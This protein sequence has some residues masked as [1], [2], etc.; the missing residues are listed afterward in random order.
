MA[1]ADAG[2]VGR[3]RRESALALRFG[4]GNG[5]RS[6]GRSG[7]GGSA[8][9]GLV[10]L[11]VAGRYGAGLFLLSVGYFAAGD[12]VSGHFF[13][14]AANAAAPGLAVTAFGAGAVAAALVGNV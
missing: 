9:A 2:L 14:A 4:G 7:A 5:L 10:V 12:G 6:G 3:R 13:C 11:F 1:F 8:P